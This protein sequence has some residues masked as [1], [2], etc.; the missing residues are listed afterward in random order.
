MPAKPKRVRVNDQMQRGYGYFLTKP[1]GKNF[2]PGFRPELTP[3]QLLRLGVFGGRYMT[4]CRDEFPEDWFEKAKLN[5]ERHD[6]KLNCFGVNASQSLAIWR[7]KGWIYEE[8]PRG[9]FQW[10]CR[11]YLGR[12]CPDDER[13]IKR[14]RAVRRHIAQLKK[15]CQRGDVTCRPRQ[16]QALLHWAYDS[17]KI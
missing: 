16:R 2:A 9:W 8:D 4:D 17:R 15:N 11:Y 1:M 3:K 7:A 10:Y 14:W 13:Q 12:R 5:P 6:P